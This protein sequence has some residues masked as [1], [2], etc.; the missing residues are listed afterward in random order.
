MRFT[1]MQQNA[2]ER[3]SN[4]PHE[5][6]RKLRIELRNEGYCKPRLSAVSLATSLDEPYEAMLPKWF[7]RAKRRI[8]SAGISMRFPIRRVNRCFPAIK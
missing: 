5:R 2:E 1:E 3:P 8:S 7:A 4:G 6:H